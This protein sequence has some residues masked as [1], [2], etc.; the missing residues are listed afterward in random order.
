[1]QFLNDVQ[2]KSGRLEPWPKDEL[3]DPRPT[4]RADQNPKATIQITKIAETL[5][6]GDAHTCCR[7]MR[8]DSAGFWLFK[9]LLLIDFLLRERYV[10]VMNWFFW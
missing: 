2:E 1:M 8:A 7:Q 9:K 3:L 6:V 10:W 5:I 4:K